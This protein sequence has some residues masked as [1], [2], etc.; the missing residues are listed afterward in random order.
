MAAKPS[1]D[2]L[3]G[4]ISETDRDRTTNLLQNAGYVVEGSRDGHTWLS[5]PSAEKRD[6]ITHLVVADGAEWNRRLSFRD[7]LL[8]HPEV[9][10]AYMELKKDLAA[11]YPHNLDA[12]TSGKANFVRDICNRC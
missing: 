8:I 9:A 11:K 3:I 1:I 6:F 4:I 10:E 2:I 12:Y 7:Y 5:C